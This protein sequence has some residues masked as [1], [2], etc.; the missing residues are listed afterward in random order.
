VKAGIRL[1]THVARRRLNGA[2]SASACGGARLQIN[3]PSCAS[4][5]DFF[6]PARQTHATTAPRT[7]RIVRDNPH[8]AVRRMRTLRPRRVRRASCA[9][10]HIAP[11]AECARY[12][13][14][15]YVAH[16]ARPSTSPRAQ[17]AHATSAPCTSR[18]LLDNPYRPVRRMRTLRPRHV[19]RALCAT[20]HI[21][22]C[23]ECARYHRVTYVAHCA[24]QSI[25]PRAQNAHATTAP[26]TSRIVRDHPH[27]A[28]RRMRTLRPRHV[29]RASCATI[30]TGPCAQGARYGVMI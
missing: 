27:R 12:A 20:I 7:S 9:T 19:R 17:N 28:V 16:P 24:R 18:I 6:M 2:S 25:S 3:N 14:V 4:T 10:I 23:A 8:R 22:P 29:S 26:R 1:A 13:R 15:T 11:C 21:A 5:G 30:H